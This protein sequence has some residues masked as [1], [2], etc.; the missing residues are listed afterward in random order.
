M[1]NQFAYA[2]GI[3]RQTAG[4]VAANVYLLL[5]RLQFEIIPSEF[6][7]ERAGCILRP[8]DSVINVHIPSFGHLEYGYVLDAYCRAVKFLVTC[9][10]TEMYGSTAK[11]GY[12]ILR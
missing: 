9:F 12:C 5:G 7:Y 8:Y 6:H 4:R 2:T 1:L 3:L 11:H 10:P